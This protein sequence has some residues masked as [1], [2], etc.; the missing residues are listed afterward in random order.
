MSYDIYDVLEA[1]TDWVSNNVTESIERHNVDI[2]DVVEQYVSLDNKI[3]VE[4]IVSEVS[5]ALYEIDNHGAEHAG[6]WF[7]VY[8][9]DIQ[10]IFD[11]NE[12]ECMGQIS[13]CYDGLG[14]FE[15]LDDIRATGVHLL[16]HSVAMAQVYELTQCLDELND[17]LV[18][19][20]IPTEDD[21]E[22]ESF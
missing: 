5:D 20:G 16:I 9:W 12:A 18:A 14:S 13:E 22:D 2:G 15:S 8:N 11:A 6:V 19:L 7:P 4:D 3:T 1:I 17:E 21:L 10:K